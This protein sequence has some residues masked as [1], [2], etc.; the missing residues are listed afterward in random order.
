MSGTAYPITLS[1]S[2][3]GA[4]N[5]A[6]WSDGPKAGSGET[7]FVIIPFGSSASTL[8]TTRQA[9]G[10][11][12]SAVA[13]FL[14]AAETQQVHGGASYGWYVFQY[15]S[16][17]NVGSSTPTPTPMATPTPGPAG[18]GILGSTRYQTMGGFGIDI[19]TLPPLP[20]QAFTLAFN[21][22]PNG[23]GLSYARMG[24]LADGQPQG[25]NDTD[26]PWTN[27]Q[28]VV[29]AG[30]KVWGQGN[31]APAAWKTNNNVDNG[32]QLIGSHYTD[33]AN[34]I[35]TFVS[36]AAANGVPLYAFS[37]QNE[38][39]SNGATYQSMYMGSGEMT[40]FIDV[41]GPILHASNPNTKIMMPESSDPGILGLYVSSVEAD[42]TAFSYTGI[43]ATHQY[44]HGPVAPP[45]TKRP[46]WNTEWFYTSYDPGI[47][48]G[49]AL[50]N[51]AAAGILINGESVWGPFW[52]ADS[53]TQSTSAIIHVN[54]DGS[55][56]PTA[57]LYTLGNFSAFVK[58]GDILLGTSGSMSGVTI[59]PFLN[60]S[61]NTPVIVLINN[62]GASQNV[63]MSLQ[64]GVTATSLTPYV[65][66]G[67]MNLA[68]QSSV[69]VSGGSFSYIIPG[70]SVTT[71]VGAP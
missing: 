37:V 59:V 62:N 27:A 36:A 4:Y 44:G 45:S 67:S 70:T 32:G 11:Y 40:P 23:I 55:L 61:N 35:S 30:G 26:G 38:P 34:E 22:Y 5:H 29:A 42:P 9:N 54:S 10:N 3:N 25:P 13:I 63:A 51:A 65:T 43:Y 21:P 39:D 15:E 47:N 64:G 49:M 6:R 12:Q 66:S 31:S 71:L 7:G 52:L 69:S 17:N 2:C 16:I 1:I 33:Y 48:G 53:D 18:I 46:I 28:A 41:L 14:D 60:P 20:A 19:D 8:N 57:S 50:A 68:Q 56:S 24:M 58:S